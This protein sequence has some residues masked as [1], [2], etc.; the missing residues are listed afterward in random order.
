MEAGIDRGWSRHCA[1]PGEVMKLDRLILIAMA[2][3][4]TPALQGCAPAVEGDEAGECDDGVDNDQDGLLDCDDDGCSIAA[5]CTGDDDD[6]AND[7]D[8]A[9]DD[10]GSPDDDDAGD[11]DDAADDDDATPVGT[12]EDGDGVTVEAGDC[13]DGDA[14]IYPGA[15]EVWDD[16]IDQDCD[17]VADA[18]GAE[19][20]AS[21]TVDF[22]DG[23]DTTLDGCIDWSLD[24]AFEY[25]PDD[26]PEVRSFTLNF[27]ATLE[28]AFECHIV[29]TQTQVCGAGYYDMADAAG[30]TLYALMDCTGVADA[31]EQVYTATSGYLRLDTL[32]AGSVAGNFTGQPLPTTVEGYLSVEDAGVSL[33]GSFSISLEQVAVDEEEQTAC[34]VSDGDADGDGYTDAYFGGED[35]DSQN[36]G[37]HPYDSDGD[38]VDDSCGWREVSAGGNHTCGL[39]SGGGVQCWGRDY[40]GEATP[41]TGNFT[42]VSAGYQHACAI[43]E[44]GQLHCWGANG[45]GQSEPPPGT[46]TQVSAGHQFACA[47]NLAGEVDC[48]GGSYVGTAEPPSGPFIFVSAGFEHACG[49]IPTG[50]VECWGRNQFGESA[51]PSGTFAGIGAGEEA[52]CGIDATGAMQ[53]WGRPLFSFVPTVSLA[54][55]SARNR[56]VCGVDFAGVLECWGYELFQH[57]PAP[58]GQVTAAS[59]GDTHVC[60]VEPQGTLACWGND[61]DG[62]ASPP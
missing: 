6:A 7:D 21:F 59:A 11:D 54:Q 26:P 33:H 57:P 20:I 46:F 15:P 50:Y 3:S 18:E 25:D 34:A 31:Y 13:D 2:S 32:D 16:G 42:A 37:I 24:A 22:P 38:G 9:D 1:L 55:I 51:P 19:C 41:P 14:S 56:T 8:A 4:L 48:W 10:D 27:G 58:S 43:D 28:A 62:Q 12:D 35:C 17:G 49:L 53:C 39:D 29:V 45:V 23:S 30:A 5:A 44:L 36:A 40:V 52:T 61:A 47:I 60:A